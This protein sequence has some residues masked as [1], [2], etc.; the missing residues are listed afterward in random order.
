MIAL[1]RLL[2]LCCCVGESTALVCPGMRT[3]QTSLKHSQNVQHFHVNALFGTERDDAI[4]DLTKR[5]LVLET[6]YLALEKSG[7]RLECSFKEFAMQIITRI[8]KFEINMDTKFQVLDTKINKPETSIIAKFQE[9]DTKI[10]KPETSII[11]K[12]Y[13]LTKSFSVVVPSLVAITWLM[14][15]GSAEAALEVG[16]LIIMWSRFLD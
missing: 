13:K 2:F 9:L 5:T 1:L 11:A 12:I 8:D 4:A 16:L 14:M 3:L 15:G 6:R 7:E 10:D